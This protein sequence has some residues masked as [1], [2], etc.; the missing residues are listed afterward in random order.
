MTELQAESL[1]TK[2]VQH[3]SLVTRQENLI[4][5]LEAVVDRLYDTLDSVRVPS[6]ESLG[7]DS[8]KA[9]PSCRMDSHLDTLSTQIY[10]LNRLADEVAL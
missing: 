3:P 1:A 8:P 4:G 10:R 7:L 9:A 2:V 5:Q 6:P